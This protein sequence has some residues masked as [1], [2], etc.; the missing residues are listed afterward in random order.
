TALQE[1]AAFTVRNRVCSGR[2]PLAHAIL[3][4]KG[5]VFIA[6]P[7]LKERRRPDTIAF[8]YCL[9]RPLRF[10]RTGL[11]YCYA[12]FATD[13]HP[14]GHFAGYGQLPER[15][16]GRFIT[17]KMDC[18]RDGQ[19][20]L[21]ALLIGVGILSRRAEPDVGIGLTPVCGEPFL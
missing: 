4:H 18:C 21:P 9:P 14:V 5:I 13:D 3:S 12:A 8:C 20:M 10:C 15:P 1:A 16:H 11:V 7:L 6:S 17:H 19:Q 2:V